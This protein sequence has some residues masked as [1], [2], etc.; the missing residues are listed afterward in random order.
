MSQNWPIRSSFF[1]GENCSNYYREAAGRDLPRDNALQAAFGDEEVDQ[2][3]AAADEDAIRLQKQGVHE[4][5]L[6]ATG[7]A[8]HHVYV[9]DVGTA[10]ARNRYECTPGRRSA[11]RIMRTSA[12]VSASVLINEYGLLPTGAARRPWH[13]SCS[14]C[15]ATQIVST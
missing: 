15:L 4:S 9:Y 1:H 7:S 14:R 12:M 8:D 13:L 11:L 10:L 5:F 2:S 6:M 3:A